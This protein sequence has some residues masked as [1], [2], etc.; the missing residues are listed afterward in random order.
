MLASN[1]A[2]RSNGEPVSPEIG[3][4]WECRADDSPAKANAHREGTRARLYDQER[5]AVSA[6]LSARDIRQAMA[7]LGEKWDG[8]TKRFG[9]PPLL[10]FATAVESLLA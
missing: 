1:S 7:P 2:G 3:Q 4:H 8:V 5:R 9:A 6:G 10:S